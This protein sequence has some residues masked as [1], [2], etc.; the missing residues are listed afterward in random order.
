[1]I[2]EPKSLQVGVSK[3]RKT[4]KKKEE[5]AWNRNV[6]D[7]KEII[8]LFHGG[9][10]NDEDNK[11]RWMD[12]TWMNVH[13]LS[14]TFYVVSLYFTTQTH[15]SPPLTYFSYHFL[16]L[17]FAFAFLFLILLI[18]KMPT[19]HKHCSPNTCCHIFLLALVA[20]EQP[21]MLMETFFLSCLAVP[22]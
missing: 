18:T 14:L 21:F 12:L 2:W 7:R 15:H 8:T 11:T 20:I 19:T 4:R 22:Y 3:F 9:N 5:K 16:F 10:E 6:W 17:F 13:N 1:M